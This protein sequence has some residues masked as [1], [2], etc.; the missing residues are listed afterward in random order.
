LNNRLE[1]IKEKVKVYD[2]YLDQTDI[3]WTEEDLSDLTWLIEQAELVSKIKDFCEY[4]SGIYA[5]LKMDENRHKVDRIFFN[6]NQRAY[7]TVVKH[8]NN[9]LEN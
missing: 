3:N 5:D 6:G 7:T 4:E 1:D 8:I 9:L 2:K